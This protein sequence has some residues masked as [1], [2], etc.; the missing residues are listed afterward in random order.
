MPLPPI[1]PHE[2]STIT[3]YAPDGRQYQFEDCSNLN[4]DTRTGAAMFLKA[5]G[6]MMMIYGGIITVEQ[7]V[8]TPE[9]YYT[10]SGIVVPPSPKLFKS[11]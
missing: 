10:D 6:R 5:D 11:E 8:A 3:F 2:L 7:K 9:E 4:F 1:P